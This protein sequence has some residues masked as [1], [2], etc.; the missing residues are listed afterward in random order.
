MPAPAR[1]GDILLAAI[2]ARKQRNQSGAK[3]RRITHNT[4]ARFESHEAADEERRRARQ[5]MR[6]LRSKQR[7]AAAKPCGKQCSAAKPASK[8]QRH[9]QRGRAR[10]SMKKLRSKQRSAAAK[11]GRKQCSVAK[12]EGN[13]ARHIL[14]NCCGRRKENCKCF[15]HGRGLEIAK[16]CKR[17]N[18]TATVERAKT[19]RIQ[20]WRDTGDMPAYMRQIGWNAS[21][22]YSWLF[23]IA[24]MWRHFSNEEFWA[25]L[26][27]M[28]AVLQNKPP[29]FGLVEKA[30]R[31]FQAKKIAYHGGVF[32]SGSTLTRYRYGSAAKPG[33]WKECNDN[34][35]FISKETLA[36]KV[37]WHVAGTLK[38]SFDSLQRQ[39]SRQCWEACTQG[40]LSQLQEHTVGCFSDY[41][42]KVA[43]DGILL[44]QPCLEQVVSWWPMRCPAYLSSLPKLYP[45]CTRSQEDLFLAGCHFHYSLKDRLP[46]FLLRDSLAQICWAE[47]GVS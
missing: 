26:M 42:L 13:P 9:I 22:Q 10:L 1:H 45:V 40:F 21:M 15:T 5:G 38:G 25:A 23:P 46:K 33:T 19:S 17:K 35:D 27:N 6:K 12:P 2:K 47:R 3:H 11:P 39:P 31:S 7:S 30:M 41:S 16:S 14:R 32:F 29:D 37:M 8:R 43:L 28:G 34:Q 44:S 18:V 24:I 36:L 20:T 4:L